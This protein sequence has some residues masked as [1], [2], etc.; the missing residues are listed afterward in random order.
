MSRQG[1][2]GNCA[3]LPSPAA[4]PTGFVCQVLYSEGRMGTG[5]ARPPMSHLP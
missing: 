1:A 2:R 5:A 3:R 4:H